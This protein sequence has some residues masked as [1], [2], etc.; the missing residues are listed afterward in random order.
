[1][2]TNNGSGTKFQNQ[3]SAFA[4]F[5]MQPFNQTFED[6]PLRQKLLEQH[7]ATLKPFKLEKI[8]NLRDYK[9]PRA[10]QAEVMSYDAIIA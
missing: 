4:E 7:Q 9:K 1:M 3:A 10:K 8:V 5:K 6:I 2:N